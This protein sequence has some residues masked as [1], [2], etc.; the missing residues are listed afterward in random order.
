MQRAKGYYSGTHIDPKLPQIPY[1]TRS[2]FRNPLRTLLRNL[3][4]GAGG[5]SKGS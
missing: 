4:E 5:L 3:L 2:P 1:R